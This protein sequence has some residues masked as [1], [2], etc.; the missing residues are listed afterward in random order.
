MFDPDSDV[1]LSALTPV[2]RAPRAPLLGLPLSMIGLFMWETTQ[3]EQARGEVE[4][5]I[6]H[7]GYLSFIHAFLKSFVFFGQSI[8]FVNVLGKSF[9]L[10]HFL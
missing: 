9:A 5:T 7:C 1:A 6:F 4:V 8:P 3:R 10:L 2:F